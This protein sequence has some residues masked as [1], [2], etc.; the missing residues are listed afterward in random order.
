MKITGLFFPL[1]SLFFS[2]FLSAT[3]TNDYRD[4]SL[5]HNV[6]YKGDMVSIGNTALVPPTTQDST[7]CSTYTNGPYSTDVAS[8]NNY[9]YL[10]GYQVD[11]G[12]TNSTTAE[13]NLPTGATIKWA[14]LYWQG[15]V[16][17][18][19]FSTTM[20]IKIKKDFGTYTTITYDDLDYL[21][22][23]GK[24]GYT[25]YS[26]FKD[27]TSTFSANNWSEGNYTVADIPVVEGKIDNLGT[28]GAWNLV[29]IYEDLLSST[30]KFRSFSIFDGWKVVKDVL[31]YTD[32]QINLSGF[33][34]PKSTPINANISVFAAEGDKHIYNDYLK[35]FNYNNSPATS[36]DIMPSG[37]TSQT[38]NSS[39]SGTYYR[40]PNLINNN[41]IDIQTH[42]IGDYL[43]TEQSDIEFHFTSTQDT[44]WP[45]LLAF[46]TELYVPV[47]CYDY[48]YKQQGIYF[49]EEND[50]LEYPTL[51]DINSTIG[52]VIAGE[53]I[54]T[55]IFIRNLVDSDI[56]VTN[57]TV[58]ITDINVTQAT[59]IADSTKLAKIGNLTPV[60]LNDA[61]DLNISTD[62]NGDQIKGITI[63]NMSSNDNFY[64]Y[65]SLDPKNIPEPLN[66][67]INVDATYNLVI[68]ANTTIPYIL[69]LGANV[70]MCSSGNF[71][72]APAKGIFNVV[73][74]NYYDLDIGGSSPYYNLPTQVTSR[75]GN[76]K[77]ISLDANNTDTLN[78]A[79]TIVAIEM[80][81]VSAF[82]DTKA[83]CQ[84]QASSIS[85]RIWVMFDNNSTSTM[86]DQAA[87]TAGIGVN[88]TLSSSA[89]FYSVAKQNTAFRVSYNVSNDN[90]ED[91]VKVEELN[92][93]YK[94]LNFS[95]IVQVVGACAQ[96]VI[97]P[98][99]ATTTSIAKQAATACGNSGNFISAAHLQACMECIYGFNTKLV[100]S[101]DNFA[102]RPEAFLM[103]VDD[104]NQT[105]STNPLTPQERLTTNFSGITG[106]TSNILNMA[107]DYKYNLEINATNHLNNISSMGY[108]KSFNIS[109]PNDTSEY[110]WEPRTITTT[111]AN[112]FCNDNTN[113]PVDIRF[114]NGSV[115]INSSVNQVGEYRLSIA[116]T[117]WTAVDSDATYMSHH[118]GLYF[119]S[120]L[121]CIAGS[122][123][124]NVNSPILNGCNIS[125][126][127]TNNETSLVYNDYDI[128]FH[129]YKFN[130]NSKITMGLNNRDVNTTD[131]FSNFVYMANIN[132]AD[133]VNM[134]V[135]VNSIITPQGYNSSS[136]TNFVT[137]CF[138]KPL[139][140]NISKSAP[141]NTQLDYRYML[142]DKNT[143][144]SVSGLIPNVTTQDANITTPNTFFAK[145]M[146]GVLDSIMNL[147][148]DRN[149]SVVA[150]PED[151]NY[152]RVTVYD[153]RTFINAD[154]LTNKTAQS[155]IS[156]NG[157]NG[158]N[159]THYFGRTAARKTRIV[160]DSYPCLS[161]AN[162][163]PDVLIYYEAYC[164][165]NTNGNTCER[166][167]LPDL[168][169]RYIQRVDSRWYVNLNHVE[170]GD[171]NLTATNELAASVT[172]TVP[173]IHT[174][175][176]GYTKDSV[177]SYD[178]TKGL[179][180]EATMQSTVSNW[181]V[182]DEDNTGATTNKHIVVFQ[183]ETTWTGQHET[184]T[185]TQTQK[186]RRV[187]RRTMW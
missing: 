31:G 16:A 162:G 55:T 115:E 141:L 74:N 107:A 19:D 84:E 128:T 161:G 183:P 63:G 100:C 29:V 96:P 176:N 145:T 48:A 61:T 119:L 124:Q 52:S 126:S 14:G 70:P 173:T 160:C 153:P 67:G 34:T 40:V 184:N 118:T 117:T 30:Q 25:S 169:G 149:Q 21:S 86:F 60:A 177:H 186:V 93:E 185:T 182:Y 130:I 5:R 68:D 139:D 175:T 92:G 78:P 33:Y 39:I 36:V 32:V 120:G 102:I 150:N 129:P 159:I 131:D 88:N 151:I 98:L 24:T 133:D 58:N 77:V 73:H 116:D 103:H 164:Y 143:T 110:T 12:T 95:E 165:G 154:L 168:A 181:I 106:A 1:L 42:S 50:G 13:L 8:A 137:G 167:L 49:T 174:M 81:D 105:D 57:M 87:L 76:F 59:Y 44:Y 72:Y 156:L 6:F 51:T 79:S 158:Q 132:N 18:T 83:S 69:N 155:N 178:G 17:D 152:S 3:V 20:N 82:H 64:I 65:Y 90:N 187:N 53:P 15:L 163:E 135:Q 125:S 109:N 94:I 43:Q 148:F 85:E 101:R 172:V 22:G 35:S 66:M 123:T 113:K 71:S 89:E 140:I 166:T 46:S 75:E 11:S 147:N 136:L 38:F 180:Y 179:P 114:L 9:Y 4:F 56:D 121:D 157:L 45:S 91:L 2:S 122:T 138:A 111:N 170:S 99:N 28:Y 142:N 134:S 146:N 23:S 97:Y 104:Q 47:F 80:I 108:T 144:G 26:A 112:S 7:I 171:G 54:E 10:C 41:G 37:E 127:H 62:T 27:M